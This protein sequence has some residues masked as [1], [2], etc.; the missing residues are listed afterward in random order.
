MRRCE[1]EA[2]LTAV[3]GAG[4]GSDFPSSGGLGA[5]VVREG[6]HLGPRG[7]AG[8]VREGRRAILPAAGGREALRRCD[9]ATVGLA[10][11]RSAPSARIGRRSFEAADAALDVF[12]ALTTCVNECDNSGVLLEIQ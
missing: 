3:C 6:A 9:A 1:G 4:L 8:A 2:A 10:T 11:V 7:R 12:N 5:D